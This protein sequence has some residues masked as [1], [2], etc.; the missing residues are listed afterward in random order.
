VVALAAA[1]LVRAITRTRARS[2]L[3]V[4]ISA[5]LA[6]ACLLYG[7]EIRVDTKL[8]SLLPDD[9]PSVSALDEL[10]SRKGSSEVLTVVARGNDDDAN[11][12]VIDGLAEAIRGWEETQEVYTGRD[13]TRIR[14]SALYF[15]EVEE[16]ESLRDQLVEEHRAGV[17]SV[18]R[19][20][21]ADGKI[22]AD[23]VVVDE[24][25]WEEEF[26]ELDWDKDPEK[27]SA[28]PDGTEAEADPSADDDFD[29][30][31]W[32]RDQKGSVVED[33][34]LTTEEMDLIWPE[35]NAEG[36]IVWESTVSDP[37]RSEK[38]NLRL[39]KATLTKL[40]TDLVFARS[41]AQRID[42]HVAELE[43][44]GIGA[45]VEVRVVSAYAVSDDV[46]TIMVDLQ[47]ATWLSGVLVLAVLLVGFRN[48]R[49]VLLVLFPMVVAM[50]ITL[51]LATA[52]YGELN[53]LTGFLFAVL[54]GMGVDFSVHL[55]SLRNQQ[56]ERAD[57]GHIVEVHL[58]PLASTML[59]TVGCLFVLAAGVFKAFQEFGIIS[60]IGVILC[61][62]CALVL[63][64]ALDTLLGPM[65]PNNFAKRLRLLALSAFVVIG[66]W[67]APKVDFEKDTR[68]LTTAT[69]S[70]KKKSM[71]YGSATRRCSKTL[72]L[73]ADN[74][75][76]L[77]TVVERLEADKGN[78]LP[79]AIPPEADQTLQPW[80]QEVYSVAKMLPE[81]QE[82]KQ[83]VLEEIAVETS[84]FL[85]ELPDMDEEAQ[86]FRTHLEA[87]ER[88]S[89][90][91]PLRG[92]ELPG[93]ALDPFSE[94]DG[95]FDRIGHLCMKI[96][97]YH[98]D[99]LVALSN[100]LETLTEGTSTRTADSRLVFADLIT[101]VEVDTKRLPLIALAV[102]LLLLAVDLRSIR[103]TLICFASLVLG[104][105]L[106][107]GVM[108]LW[109]MHVNFFNLA[110]MP[111][112]V[113]LGIDASI[114]LWH[115]RGNDSLKATG[116]ASLIAAL[117]TIAGFAGMLA[118]KHPGLHS[119]GQLGVVAIILSVGV[120]FLMLYTFGRKK[121]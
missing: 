6:V 70:G 91:A 56:G 43:S 33:G 38:A 51:A 73:I 18:V 62:L 64:P 113:G 63:V 106:T 118:A 54:F 11:A 55:F 83:K 66:I 116:R 102:I 101:M 80:I 53:A 16:L 29:L 24:E 35:E 119:I 61:F 93:W 37:Y 103:S 77:D 48:A 46:D 41:V 10:K 72:A 39:L 92:E 68:V 75:E 23:E 20:G 60:G 15:M 42:G 107:L 78:T 109:P 57:W 87:L 74:P 111:A 30:R 94:K 1:R 97:S 67:G 7:K 27:P 21:L 99:E 82:A 45:G 12:A 65:R 95:H 89:K 50:A 25:N 9:A 105:G 71:P 26:D 49:A 86:E 79:G 90:A 4:M 81:D 52:A 36:E 58:R 108:G 69:T 34:R 28:R 59:T 5:L 2:G 40:P 13:Y 115:A 104:L 88:L 96:R 110:V 47:R 112:V 76:D 44:R 22:E 120:A 19:P 3:V 31:E 85:A 32:L 114:H 121:S 100:H 17:A 8:T 98:L 117:T 84:G 14:D